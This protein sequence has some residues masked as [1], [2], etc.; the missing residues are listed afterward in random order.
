MTANLNET[1]GWVI[2]EANIRSGDNGVGDLEEVNNDDVDDEDEDKD[3]IQ[4]DGD[5]DDETSKK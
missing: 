4:E 2:K 3:E 5:A 1:H